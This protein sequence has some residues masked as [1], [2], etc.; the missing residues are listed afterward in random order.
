LN[1]ILSPGLNEA[2]TE[3]NF[4]MVCHGDPVE[5]PALASLPALEK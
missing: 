5:V 4:A 2:K 3:L 1:N